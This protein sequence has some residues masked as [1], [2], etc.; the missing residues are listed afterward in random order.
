MNIPTILFL[1][2]SF[3]SSSLL[4]IIGSYITISIFYNIK[5]YRRYLK[6]SDLLFFSIKDLN[7]YSKINVLIDSIIALVCFISLSLHLF[8]LCVLFL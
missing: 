3:M 2:F 7:N 4:F 8:V 1:S 5:K 6:K